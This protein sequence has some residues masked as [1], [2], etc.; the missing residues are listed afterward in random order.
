MH[1]QRLVRRGPRSHKIGRRL[2]VELLEPRMCLSLDVPA[3]SSLPAAAKTIY[4]DF[5][6]HVT[7]GTSW[8]SYFNQTT[9]NSP[10]YNIDADG[11]NF[12]A[13]ELTQIENAW[14]RIAEDYYPFQ[15]NVTT[16]DPGIEALRNTGGGDTQWGIRV[17]TTTDNVGCGCG[18]IA[19]IDSFNW[20]SDTPVFVY[21][22]GDKNVAEAASHEIGHSLGLSHDG[23]ATAG[24]YT[25]HG[26]GETGWAPIMGVGYSKNATQW[27]KG[28]YYG[29][30]NA[31]TGANYSKGP[32][33][34]AII[35]SYNGFGY[36]ADDVGNT[37]ASATSLTVSG[38]S[39]S[40]AGVIERTTDVDYFGF[41]T[42]AGSVTLNASPFTPGPN[43]D[44]KLD[45]FDANDTLVASANPSTVLTAS[46]TATLAAG[47][48]YLRVDGT[49]VGNPTVSPPTGYTEYA[50]LGRY[51]VS[52]TIV[53]AVNDALS[54]AATDAV[55]SEGNSGTTPFT[56][57]VTRSGVTT[58][59]TTVDF[60]VTGSS[61]APA[62]ATD[63]GGSLPSGSLTFGPGV[64]SQDITVNVSGDTTNESNEGFTVTLS[65]ASGTTQISNASATGTIQND[66][67]P[68]PA[69]TLSI[70][71]TS[72]NK[73][74]GTGASPTDFTFTVTRS[75][76]TSGTASVKYTVKGVGGS[77]AAKASDF[78]GG[79]FPT[80][81]TVNFA[82][83]QTS[84]V[85]TIL[86]TAD[87]TKE[88]NESFRVTLSGATN[89]TIATATADG[90]IQNDDGAGA[91]ASHSHS[92]NDNEFINVLL[93]HAFPLPEASETFVT[94]ENHDQTA[95][96][97]RH[98]EYAGLLP[99]G[100]NALVGESP[101][102][103]N[104]MEQGSAAR[105]SPAASQRTRDA[106]L[107]AV[108][109]AT[110]VGE[111]WTSRSTSIRHG[112]RVTTRDAHGLCA[113]LVDEWMS[114]AESLDS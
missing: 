22:T 78:N 63:F 18:G 68:P 73:P 97:L 95:P 71:A 101:F 83:G 88:K 56:F 49:G 96:G 4:L 61:A 26:T 98:V 85:V 13:T 20:N 111:R 82:V 37:A 106:A 112:E 92:G 53:D 81:V 3:F 62:N 89:A 75:G 19:Y 5:D 94:D 16:V 12:S 54:I 29:S 11:A 80:N 77:T 9:I 6:G 38:T 107:S 45:L 7:Q 27:D 14:K 55:K 42:G 79:V 33:D 24:Y 113:E 48:Y 43:L 40:A 41:V 114:R 102:G 100:G 10:A 93:P 66:D 57:T 32:D 15:V 52:G 105:I 51:T 65:N 44:V 30:N 108:M 8:N 69:P 60:A 25:G 87:S 110:D 1:L 58:G 36:R 70:A 23:T 59:T 90:I 31:G 34:L 91:G 84:A 47:Q 74:E 39:V 28:E 50:S 76:D 72:A 21:N 2:G 46:I 109:Q 99:F 35:T 104:R 67:A 86:V 17:V 64:T 103:S